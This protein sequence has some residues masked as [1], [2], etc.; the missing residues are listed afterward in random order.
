MKLPFSSL[1]LFVASTYAEDLVP[2]L[3]K[4]GFTEFADSLE[5]HPQ[6]LARFRERSDIKIYAPHNSCYSESS[7]SAAT[8][9]NVPAATPTTQVT[10]TADVIA[11]ATATVDSNNAARASLPVRR[12]L[13]KRTAQ[14]EEEAQ[15][16]IQG[17][18]TGP[19]PQ[20]KMKKRQDLVVDISLA[21][22]P[23]S[24]FETQKTF[25]ED[26][27]YVNLGDGQPARVVQ[28]YASAKPDAA[29]NN[30]SDAVMQIKSGVDGL[31]NQLEGGPW[32][33]DRGLIYGVDAFFQLPKPMGASLQQAGLSDFIAAAASG[34]QT[35]FLETK[36]GI[37]VLAPANA[38]S[39][40]GTY[41]VREHVIESLQYIDGLIAGAKFTTTAGTQLEV[42]ERN[43]GVYVNGVRVIKSD[44]S[45]KNG[46]VHTLERSAR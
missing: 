20:P 40:N 2:A 14:A 26:Q 18:H 46:V 17:A 30:C 28:Y 21:A 24:N 32:K 31:A 7:A 9:I 15:N 37:T 8:A 5:R 16:G 4:R 1:L 45:C 38:E 33:W 12:G 25:L 39:T 36:P 35:D 41:D 6:L 23:P 13:Y 42:V 43:G 11:A 34:G 22:S 10:T 27:A 3:R 29:G 19:P 44:I